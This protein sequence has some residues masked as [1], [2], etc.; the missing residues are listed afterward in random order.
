M[1]DAPGP[2]HALR[3]RTLAVRGGLERSG[4]DETAESLYLTSGFVYESAAQAEAAFKDEVEHYIYS[5]YGNPTVTVFEERMRLMEG[6]EACFATASGMAAVFTA[7]AALCGAGDRVVASRALFG[8]CFV[9]LDEILPRWGVET[10]FVDGAD[11]DQWQDALATPTTA[12]FFE[13]PS[14]PMQELVDIRAVSD[15]AHAAGATVVVDNVFGTPVFS[16]PLAHGADVVVYSATKHIDGQGRAL[17]GAVLGPAEYIDGPVKNLMRHTGPSLSPFNAWVMTK[18]L[19]TLDLRVRAMADSTLHIAQRLE[20]WM[21]DGRGLTRVVY[22]HLPSHPQHDLALRQLEGGAGTVVT[23][24]VVGGKGAAFAMLDAF[25]L[26]DISNNL[27]DAKSLTTHPATTTH[28][29]L[30]PEARAAVGIT[31]GTVRVSVGLEDTEDLLEDLDHALA[32]A[33]AATR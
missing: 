17:G 31:D 9:I 13:T 8:S 7:M 19:E 10:V 22:P 15:L 30:T 20:Q 2:E 24:E 16:H 18:G 1:S 11:L 29:R 6:A 25:R 5:R 26:V 32:A 27:G 23:F 33:E 12:V 28:R 21:A 3:P 14:N 4:F